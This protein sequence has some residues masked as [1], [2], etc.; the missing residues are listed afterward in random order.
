MEKEKMNELQ[1][2]TIT[3]R[4]V[5]NESVVGDVGRKKKS[6]IGMSRNVRR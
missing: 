6:K 2:S 1:T 3:A 4:A 5:A